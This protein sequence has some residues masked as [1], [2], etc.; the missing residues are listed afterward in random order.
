M[1]VLDTKRTEFYIANLP[2]K[3]GAFYKVDTTIVQAGE[4]KLR[5]IVYG[6]GATDLEFHT[7]N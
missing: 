3:V 4:V 5:V 1:S 7:I 6:K 2:S